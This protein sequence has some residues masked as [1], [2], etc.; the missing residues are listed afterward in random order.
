MVKTDAIDLI[1]QIV[2]K[3]GGTWVDTASLTEA[4]EQWLGAL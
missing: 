3:L 4:L 2:E 1:R